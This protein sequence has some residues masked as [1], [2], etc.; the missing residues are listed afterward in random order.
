MIEWESFL[1]LV[2]STCVPLPPPSSSTH[3]LNIQTALQHLPPSL[4]ST[5]EEKK[6][7]SLS[8]IFV[9][10][11]V[12]KYNK[13]QKT[14]DC[15]HETL[16]KQTLSSSLLLPSSSSLCLSSSSLSSPSSSSRAVFVFN[17]KPDSFLSLSLRCQNKSLNLF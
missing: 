1:L 4:G 15:R 16:V 9:I 14:Q 5:V 2:E 12:L 10:V 6:H 8:L 3:V 7:L 11:T 17:G 13:Q